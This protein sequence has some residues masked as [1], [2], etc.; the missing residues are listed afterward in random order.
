LAVPAIL[1]TPLDSPVN[2]IDPPKDTAPPPDN[3]PEV[4][5]VMEELDKLELVT[6]PVAKDT[7]PSV[8]EKLV[9]EKEAIPLAVVDASPIL[10][11]DEIV[12]LWGSPVIVTLA[13]GVKVYKTLG[14]LNSPE[15][16]AS[17]PDKEPFI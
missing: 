11:L 15:K 10:T 12:G 3:V 17:F 4:L 9:D 8:T 5:I 2:V 14:A 13:P 1:V 6:P 16:E 7:A